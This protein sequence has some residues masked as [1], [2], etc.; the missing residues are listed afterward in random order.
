[1]FNTHRLAVVTFLCLAPEICLP[2]ADD[3]TPEEN[4]ISAET[5]VG[6]ISEQQEKKSRFE[7]L[8]KKPENLLIVPIPTSSPTFGTGDPFW[9]V[10]GAFSY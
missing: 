6:V 10:A 5:Q 1:M 7:F 3:T 4:L 2:A 8:S 9:L